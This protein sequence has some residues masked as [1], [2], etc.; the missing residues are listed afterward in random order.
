M[1]GHVAR[2]EVTIDATPQRAWQAL[3]DPETVRQWMVGTEVRTDWR[4]GS[5]I[6]W[7]GEL[8]GRSYQ[9]KGEVLEADAPRRLSVTHYSPLMGQPDRPENY[10]TGTYTLEASSDSGPTTVTLE[11]DG[12]ESPEQAEQFGQDWQSMLEALKRSAEAA[13][14]R[15]RENA[16]GTRRSAPTPASRR[17]SVRTALSPDAPRG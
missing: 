9:D 14:K 11:Q 17:R 5:P 16:S 6:T 13:R 3:T 7:Q 10:H 15:S 12:N 2:A 1:R 8:H 4:V